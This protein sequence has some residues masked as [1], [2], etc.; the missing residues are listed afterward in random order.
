MQYIITWSKIYGFIHTFHRYPGDRFNVVISTI[1]PSCNLKLSSSDFITIDVGFRNDYLFGCMVY[2]CCSVWI[3]DIGFQSSFS[4]ITYGS[5]D[6]QC[7]CIIQERC[8]PAVC[9]IYIIYQS[10]IFVCACKFY[11]T[12]YDMPF[13]VICNRL[14]NIAF[15]VKQVESKVST[16]KSSSDKCL[17]QSKLHIS[18]A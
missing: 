2:K 18:T 7:I 5:D 3:T 13:T 17:L 8:I 1:R 10:F 16:G 4:V 6:F 15:F 12:E 9:F 14:D 11:R